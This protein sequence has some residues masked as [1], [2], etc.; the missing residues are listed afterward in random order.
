MHTSS[1]SPPSFWLYMQGRRASR[2]VA[3]VVGDQPARADDARVGAPSAPAAVLPP[4]HYQPASQLQAASGNGGESSSE[5]P[6]GLSVGASSISGGAVSQ[7]VCL[8]CGGPPSA[9]ASSGGVAKLRACG[10]CMSV[11][12]CSK[13][14]QKK[15]WGE[16]GHK[17]DAHSYGRRGSGGWAEGWET[18]WL[19]AGVW[20]GGG[21]W[22]LA[23]TVIIIIIIKGHSLRRA[24]LQPATNTQ[25]SK[26][27]PPTTNATGGDCAT[28]YPGLMT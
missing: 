3:A 27:R 20:A 2:A 8:M 1:S 24:C 6:G 28:Q 14:C 15:H 9:S 22:V 16:G 19:D 23:A 4:P 11:R 26:P 13:E 12:Y 18:E 7:H 10:R 17:E 5:G 21:G 25:N